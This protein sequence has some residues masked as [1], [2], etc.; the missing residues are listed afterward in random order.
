MEEILKDIRKRCRMAM[1]GI[2]SSSMRKQG[3]RYKLNFGV[4]IQKIKEISKRYTP[5]KEL[6][7]N[8]WEE[9]VREL[10]ILATLLFPISEYSKEIADKWVRDIEHQEIREQICINLLQHLP[11]AEQLT[12]EWTAYE[13]ENIRA[14]GYWLLGY[15]VKT[16]K[17]Q[18][19]D[20]DCYPS[21][22]DDSISNNISLKNAVQT[23]LKLIGRISQSTADMILG[24]LESLRTSTDPIEQEIYNSIAFEFEYFFE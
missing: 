7:E 6:A 12:K 22:W 5:N 23:S 24:N 19:V 20:I 8:L 17:I 18:D 3:I 16:N 21:I 10:K 9:D 2:A 13:N 11:F 15:L 14:S 4:S 1:N